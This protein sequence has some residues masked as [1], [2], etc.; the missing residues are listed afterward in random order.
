MSGALEPAA[1]LPVPC[2]G[3]GG[4][5]AAETPA[6]ML[7]LQVAAGTELLSLVDEG[8]IAPGPQDAVVGP[9][10]Q[11]LPGGAPRHP[12]KGISAA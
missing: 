1:H 2:W 12:R 5:Q 9:S 8:A 10:G 6:F 11:D 3:S 4:E 7:L